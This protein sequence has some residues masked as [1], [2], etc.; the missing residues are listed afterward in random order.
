MKFGSDPEVFAVNSYNECIPPSIIRFYGLPTLGFSDKEKKHPLFYN[1]KHIKI[2]EDGAAFEFNISPSN[3]AKEV[4]K[5]VEEG[6]NILSDI[7]SDFNLKVYDRPVVKFNPDILVINGNIDEYIQWCCRFGCDI[8]LDIYSGKYSVDIDASNIMKRFAGGHLHISPV[9]HNNYEIV[10]KLLDI[11]CG[12]T[13]IYNTP[14]PEEEKQRQEFYG[15]PGKIRLQTYSNKVQGIEYRTPSISWLSNIETVE[16]MINMATKAIEI[17]YN[18][19]ESLNIIGKYLQ[20]SIDNILTF[21]KEKA[22]EILC[23]LK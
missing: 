6:K 8:D 23:Q 5:K 18:R 13:F 14:Y 17:S 20:K 1:S 2:I 19:E 12:N 9:D 7:L 21:N 3:T 15:R 11:Y 16:N 22:G 4:Y 10:T